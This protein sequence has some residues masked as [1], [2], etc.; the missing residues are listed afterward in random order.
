MNVQDLVGAAYDAV[1]EPAL[2]PRVLKEASR[3]FSA[4]MA[5]LRVFDSDDN[6]MV[7]IADG[8]CLTPAM[9]AEYRAEWADRDLHSQKAREHPW[10]WNK[11]IV[12]EFA[13]VSAEE[14]RRSAYIQDFLLKS[15]LCRMVAAV[16]KDARGMATSAFFK[17]PSAPLASE[18]AL[19]EGGLLLPHLNRAVRLAASRIN[20]PLVSGSL[21]EG[22]PHAVLLLDD[23]G[24]VV[25]LN[26]HAEAFSRRGGFSVCASG[27]LCIK[28]AGR[29]MID[30]LVREA[31]RGTGRGGV[32]RMAL[33]RADGRH[34]VLRGR[35]IGRETWPCLYF[36]RAAILIE[37]RSLE[38]SPSAGDRLQHAFGLTPAE[39]AVAL[40]FAE[41]MTVAEIAQQRGVSEETVKSQ[42]RAILRKTGASRRS[43][44]TRVVAKLSD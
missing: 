43:A 21:F 11:P 6:E 16:A 22:L 3:L 4:D 20:A 9:Y 26:A 2:W 35:V 7:M 42:S 10:I 33:H 41:D 44:L 31:R 36:Q 29:D 18:Q 23:R 14:E 34:H 30:A 38:I 5:V 17:S 24:R 15:D 39:A 25:W 32:P 27:A 13:L 40:A 19:H 37:C 28:G 8:A 1:L 12:P